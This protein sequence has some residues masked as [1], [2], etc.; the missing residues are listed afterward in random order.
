MSLGLLEWV[1]VPD[2]A[3]LYLVVKDMQIDFLGETGKTYGPQRI[4][5][6][7]LGVNSLKGNVYA[8]ICIGWLWQNR[9]KAL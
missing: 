4:N 5:V 8:Q 2:I 7:S 6:A 3:G 1:Y 9:K